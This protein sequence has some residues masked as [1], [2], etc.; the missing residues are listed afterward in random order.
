MND[1]RFGK[2]VFDVIISVCL[3]VIFSPIFAIIIL[4]L[5]IEGLFIKSSRGSLFYSEE[6]VSAGIVFVIYKFRVFKKRALEEFFAARGRIDTKTL[7]RDSQALTWTGKLLKQLYLD[8]L[9]QL[10]NV[11]RGD[12][13][14]VGPRPTNVINYKKYL[15]RGGVAKKIQKA[16]LTGY[17]QSHKGVKLELNQEE[18]DLRYA[19]FCKK[20]PIWKILLSDLHTLL[21]SVLT[22]IRAE[23][24]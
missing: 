23:G 20:S 19:E 5:F 22:V 3:L 17:F 10:F 2:R 18:C 11:L 21:L 13:S 1:I 7:E 8:E 6:R 4:A 16:G 12:M 24:I 15:E 9:P 14:F